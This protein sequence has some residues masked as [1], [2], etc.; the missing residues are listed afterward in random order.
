MYHHYGTPSSPDSLDTAHKAA[1]APGPPGGAFTVLQAE[2]AVSPPLLLPPPPGIATAPAYAPDERRAVS[3]RG[4]TDGAVQLSLR[5]STDVAAFPVWKTDV[6][7]ALAA[8]SPDPDH[9]SQWATNMCGE[10]VSF[11][12]LRSSN[13]FDRLDAGLASALFSVLRPGPL[14]SRIN[15]QMSLAIEA[16]R[17]LKSRQIFPAVL[18]CARHRQRRRRRIA[19]SSSRT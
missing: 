14:L 17:P 10:A 7:L 3:A 19:F 11:D 16:G 8:A 2:A 12:A 13:G 6:L 15:Q 18:C 4:I 9:V 1:P 5:A